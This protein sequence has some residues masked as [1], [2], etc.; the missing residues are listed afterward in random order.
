MASILANMPDKGYNQDEAK[1]GVLQKKKPYGITR[2]VELNW[3][4]RSRASL[5]L[6]W[7][8]SLQG[9]HGTTT[10]YTNALDDYLSVLCLV[11]LPM[12]RLGRLYKTRDAMKM[13][14]MMARTMLCSKVQLQLQVAGF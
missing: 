4:W 7:P 3:F 13:L 2:P 11:G 14:C 1:A 12:A 5:A 9:H 8:A 6:N 10:K